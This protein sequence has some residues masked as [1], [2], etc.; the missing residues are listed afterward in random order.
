MEF[1]QKVSNR[2]KVNKMFLEITYCQEVIDG[3]LIGGW[4]TLSVRFEFQA[5][6]V[7]LKLSESFYHRSSIPARICF[8]QNSTLKW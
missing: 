2:L 3:L 5:L 4:S 8:L 1:F 7:L 6:S